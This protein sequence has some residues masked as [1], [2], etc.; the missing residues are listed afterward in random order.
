MKKKF[1]LSLFLFL[2]GLSAAIAAE[3]GKALYLSHC[4][5]CH[6]KDGSATSLGASLKGLSGEDC[7]RKLQGYADGSF[8][9][10]QKAV[11]EGIVK[12]RSPDEL[13]AIAE[14]VGGL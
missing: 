7:L 11:M 2:G 8:G 5:G 3:D 13:K 1:L 14:Y 6:G 9:G 12:K 10:N 4:A